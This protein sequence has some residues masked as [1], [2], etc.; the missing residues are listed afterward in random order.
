MPDEQV[1]SFFAGQ[2][3]FAEGQRGDFAYVVLR[4]SVEIFT[5]RDG[6]RVSIRTLEEGACF[7]EM[8]AIT[9]K[10][11]S[12]SA[13]ALTPVEL[14]VIA[15]DRV[16]RLLEGADPLLRTMMTS[17]I[18]RLRQETE[19]VVNNANALNPVVSTAM[20]LAM[21]GKLL[22]AQKNAAKPG[23]AAPARG[24]MAGGAGQNQNDVVEI[25]H[26]RAARLV[27]ELLG[28]PRDRVRALFKTM[29]GMNLLVILPPQSEPKIQF[30]PLEIVRNAEN[31]CKS[32]SEMVD[33]RLRVDA[34]YFDIEEMAESYGLDRK[35]LF[36]KMMRAEFPEEMVVFRKREAMREF[37]LFGKAYYEELKPK[38]PG[39]FDHVDDI[40]YVGI[41]DLKTELATFEPY[42]LA[43]LVKF[44]EEEETRKRLLSG[45]SNNMR[46][47]I[48][49]TIKTLP[50]AE[51]GQAEEV[52]RE[53]IERLKTRLL[54]KRGAEGERP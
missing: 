20:L 29:A 22:L 34:E 5:Q 2:Q 1:Q 46:T 36:K 41:E 35:K 30:R 17:L 51:A 42:S 23:N 19:T 54:A 14:Q 53:L 8:A 31:I 37:E 48:E 7:G 39:D 25:T 11:R 16:Q 13:L 10:A 21:E 24:G 50:D 32:F 26:S 27:A 47:V 12:T 52:G 18:E 33:Q 40:E 28:H 38:H 44:Q 45:L 3:I 43:V 4:G 49:K 6:K 15:A 9:G